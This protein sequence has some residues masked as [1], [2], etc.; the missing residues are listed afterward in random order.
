M[1]V[2]ACVFLAAAI[3]APFEPARAVLLYADGFEAANPASLDERRLRSAIAAPAPTASQLAWLLET[4][5]NNGGWPIAAAAGTFLFAVDCGAET[6]SL[7][8]DFNGNVAAP[9]NRHGPLCWA[10]VAIAQPTDSRYRFVAPGP[11]P[12]A[13][14][15]ARRYR[16]EDLDEYS[17]VRAAQEHLERWFGFGPQ[18]GLAPRHLQIL[19]PAAGDYDRVLYMHDAQSLFDPGAV[20]GGWNLQA[21]V[22]DGVLVVGI[23]NTPDRFDEYTHVQDDIGGPVG[24]EGDVYAALVHDVIRPWIEARYGPFAREAVAGASL[25]AVA[26]LHLVQRYP[27]T[28]D[29]AASLSGNVGW[30][31]I[32]LHNETLIERFDGAGHGSTAIYLDSGGGPG[33]GCLDG[34]GD[35]I[36]DDGDDTDNYCV[37]QQLHDVLLG[38]GYAAGV[39]L[40]H[41][42][43]P[44][45]AHNDATWGARMPGVL[46][47]FL[48]L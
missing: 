29:F 7:A 14:P 27:D 30:G 40:F 36:Q 43:A 48:A 3:V 39:D 21:S 33:S 42:H 9:M 5:A 37:T 31:S 28:F 1:R 4:V 10:E 38:E 17:L 25:A 20:S 2:S 16:Y 46:A 23:D 44:G 34:D 24:G 6:W 19:V 11:A 13:D 8:G 47:I 12:R 15:H 18:V 32:A 22:S 26:T 41:V 45:A 35:G